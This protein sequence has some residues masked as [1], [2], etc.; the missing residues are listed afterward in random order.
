MKNHFQRL[1]ALLLTLAV[2]LGT[3]PA[4]FAAQDG[5]F[6]DGRG[7]GFSRGNFA[8]TSKR[9]LYDVKGYTAHD[10]GDLCA[11]STE[12][13]HMAR[14]W[15][16]GGGFNTD[17][18]YM[19][20]CFR[21]GQMFD[22]YEADITRS[23]SEHVNS[24]PATGYKSDGGYIWTPTASDI[25][26]NFY[27]YASSGTYQKIKTL[28]YS[29]SWGSLSFDGNS[30][31]G[32]F[33]DSLTQN[34]A[35]TFYVKFPY[36]GVY[37]ILKG[38]ATST[39]ALFSNGDRYSRSSYWNQGD[40]K[41][42]SAGDTFYLRPGLAND[43]LGSYG[44]AG[45]KAISSSFHIYFPSFEYIPDTA[46]D[47]DS[48]SP[49]T[50]PGGSGFYFHLGD[51]S[52][53]LFSDNE[54]NIIL[55]TDGI[56]Y[57]PVTGNTYNMDGWT[58][59]YSSR[60]YNFTAN[61]TSTSVTYGDEYVTIKEGD[62]IYNIYYYVAQDS[63]QDTSC[64][65]DYSSTVT[66]AATCEAPGLMTYTC[67]KCGDTYTE[68]IPATGHTWQVKQTVKT[69]YDEEGNV[70]QQGYTVYKCATCGTEYKDD[71]GTGPPSTPDNGNSGGE[72]IWDKLGNLVG[73]ALGGII[74]IVEGVVSKFLDALISLVGM[75]VD[76]LNALVEGVMG[77]FQALPTIFSGF[78]G[79]LGATFAFLP[80]DLLMV[81]EF[82]FIAVIFV[83]LLTLIFR[84]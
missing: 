17:V 48:Y 21:C 64:K 46:L 62:T 40:L 10:N 80:E 53:K 67:S 44:I 77:I 9:F 78:T 31:Q 30:L 76:K 74:S 41:R 18:K 69:E 58:Y 8:D 6:G 42:Y 81:L 25:D 52:G 11:K 29:A 49:D 57:N 1:G 68:K 20:K 56:Y 43:K 65:H 59:D 70:T 16:R 45:S 83:G 2:M 79:F 50:R 19:C 23:Y 33:Y 26:S 71:A 39:S 12:S 47:S 34:S 4:A 55:E 28:P 36:D 63:D 7:G 27:L 24:L 84:R 37:R 13:L 5:T 3:V 14:E 15:T 38:N 61:N 22:V 54:M 75:L 32:H 51:D 72:S 66:T 73:S 60:T 82:G 35:V